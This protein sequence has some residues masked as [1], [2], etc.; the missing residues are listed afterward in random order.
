M[1]RSWGQSKRH[2][3]RYN[4]YFNEQRVS[5]WKT[6]QI[7]EKIGKLQSSNQVLT[8][9]N[10]SSRIAFSPPTIPPLSLSHLNF[11]LRQVTSTALNSEDC[12]ISLPGSSLRTH[13]SQQNNSV[14]SFFRNELFAPFTQSMSFTCELIK[15]LFHPND[16]AVSCYCSFPVPQVVNPTWIMNCFVRCRLAVILASDLSVSM[17]SPFSQFSDDSR[18]ME[19][20]DVVSVQSFVSI[21]ISQP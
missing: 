20:D 6:E 2:F 17:A 5:L 18:Q 8:T 11:S 7:D 12:K 14:S 16:S 10:V 15:P 4:L 13:K 9:E 3:K 1:N 21:Y 19:T